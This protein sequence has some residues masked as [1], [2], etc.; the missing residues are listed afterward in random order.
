MSKEIELKLEVP[1]S[2]ADSIRNGSIFDGAQGKTVRQTSTYFDTKDGDLAEAGFSLRVRS[3][4]D[5][6]TQTLKRT[7]AGEGLMSRDE[8]E[9]PVGSVEPDRSLLSETTEIRSIESL[10]A[11]RKLRPT[12]RSDV[13]R[14]S[15]R[16]RR[17][18]SELQVDFD[19]GNIHAGEQS[20]DFA[21]LEVELVS[22]DPLPIVEVARQVAERSSARL[23][24][25]S[26]AERGALLLEGKLHRVSKS[27]PVEMSAEFDVASAFAAV[28]QACIRHYRLNEPIVLSERKVEALHQA[29]VAMRRLRSAFTIFRPA[30]ADEQ[31]LRMREEL[32]WFT[33][34]LG[35]ARNLD[36]FLM[37]DLPAPAREA[38]LQRRDEAYDQVVEAMN[39]SRFRTLL[40]ELAGWVHL[41]VWRHG[42]GAGKAICSFAGK[43]LDKVWGS[44]EPTGRSLTR[45]SEE[46]RHELRI[47]VKKMRYAIEFFDR[48]YEGGKQKKRF[49]AAIEDLQE[50]L[51]KLNDLA[52]A[53]MLAD[54]E[55]DSWIEDQSSEIELL[56]EAEGALGGLAKAGPFWRKQDS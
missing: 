32:R 46:A 22:G 34:Q 42:K 15:W 1:R 51:G 48:L 38:A 50:L 39:S 40:I 24:V 9:W 23:G 2:E 26:K 16:F 18:D 27:T 44:I 36:V 5:R 20:A 28:A 53:R 19:V 29:R 56:R 54:S 6:F 10:L 33:A 52:T 21:E 37:R 8:W 13:E 49:A 45:M 17:G 14:T 47:Q 41:G 30:I 43:R 12:I 35:D 4:G 55:A 25:L 3:V 31:F 7:T 11:K